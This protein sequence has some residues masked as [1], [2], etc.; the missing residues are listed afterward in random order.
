M[1]LDQIL[2]FIL[3]G[4]GPGA[5]IAAL[6]LSI[7]LGYRGDGI[8]NVAAGAMTTFGAYVYYGLRQGFLFIPPIPFVP[9]KYSLG[10][11]VS[12]PLAVVITLVYSGLVGA[13]IE[14]VAYRPL[15]KASPVA[16]LVASVGV[17][18]TLGAII[19]LQFGGNGQLAPDVLPTTTTT[20][21]G[22]SIPTNRFMLAGI[23]AV[24]TVVLWGVYKFT[25]FGLATRAAQENQDEAVLSGLSPNLLAG[26]N[27]IAASVLAAGF[28][29]LVAPLTSLD[30]STL[31]LA[32][33]PAL[34]AAL[35]AG[36]QSF[37]IAAVFGLGLGIIRTLIQLLQTQN[38]FPTTSQGGPLPG[39]TELVYFV[40]IVVILVLKGKSLPA[41]GSLTEARLP[42]TP[43][44]MRTRAGKVI[45]G[46]WFVIAA[47]A[48][49]FSP[50]DWR[51]AVIN[52]LIGIIA[53]ISLVILTGYV[54]QVS[55]AQLAVAGTAGFILSR[56]ATQAGIGFPL[57]PVIAILGAAT[58]GTLA[59][60]AALRIRGVNLAI[61]TL[62]AATA[63][64][65]FIFN[66]PDFGAPATGSPVPSPTLFGLNLGADAEL[67][68][69]GG[70]NPSPMLGY[71]V[72]AFMI[73][74]VLLTI[75]LRRTSLGHSLL[76]VRSN[77]RAV[78]ASGI[79][80]ARVK[81]VAF[82]LSS[83]VI[84]LAGVLVS[85]NLGSVDVGRFSIMTMLSLYA[86]GY[87]G[88]ITSVVGAAI[89]GLMGQSGFM[90]QLITTAGLPVAVQGYVGGL[91]L[92]LTIVTN[93]GGLGV[94]PPWRKQTSAIAAWWQRRTGRV[95]TPEQSQTEGLS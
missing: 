85:Y 39:V 78:A 30:P 59:G 52:T 1:T 19:V 79:S 57:G 50:P 15:R 83:V 24:V 95:S 20:V 90:T 56:L 31:T 4:V 23:V 22:S 62:A 81:L 93:P 55:L 80:P 16:K 88:G 68:F 86:F 44:E 37:T 33:V 89:A 54:A 14:F 38:W 53:A 61:V 77:E 11:P 94:N 35:L 17:L 28:G 82:A 91:L 49:T 36:F 42:K 71:F 48:V 5:L 65:T 12:P 2:L 74:L 63:I 70:G 43:Y 40:L 29:I 8:V 26:A 64:S 34:A 6:A 9:L 69:G 41:R 58:L 51:Q 76:A 45:A 92:I 46:I 13:I 66:N 47:L 73:P 60:S 72:L 7:I 87:I 75:R 18:L 32:V 21:L 10:G 3:L 25:S 67:P 27:H 84:S